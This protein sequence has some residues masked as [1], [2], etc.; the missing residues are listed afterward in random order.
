[1]HFVSYV[2]YWK[3]GIK[4]EHI[5]IND[6]TKRRLFF[7]MFLN[8]QRE[9]YKWYKTCSLSMY[10]VGTTFYSN[11]THDYPIFAL[12]ISMFHMQPNQAKIFKNIWVPRPPDAV[13]ST[14]TGL[15]RCTWLFSKSWFDPTLPRREASVVVLLGI[16]FSA[17]FRF[18]HK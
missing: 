2:M 12:N 3:T 15:W 17:C 5:N 1:M 11:L 10:I 7:L 16:F 18:L 13:S 8:T 6:G 9:R 4:K 14:E